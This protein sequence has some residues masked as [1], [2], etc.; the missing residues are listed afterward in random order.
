MAKKKKTIKEI[1]DMSFKDYTD[2]TT[3]PKAHRVH[4]FEVAVFE[5][6]VKQSLGRFAIGKHLKH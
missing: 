5:D 3:A 6:T 1:T 4:D 2:F